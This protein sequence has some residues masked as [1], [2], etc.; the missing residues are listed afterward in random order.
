MRY[1]AVEKILGGRAVADIRKPIESA[2]G[3]PAAAYTSAEF[4]E[5]EQRRL[6]PQ[7]W[8][9]VA[10]AEEVAEPGDAMPVT[11]A[12]VPLIIL[13][14][15]AGE[16]RA[17][18]NVCRHRATIILEKPATKLGTLQC[19]YH[20]WTYGLDGSL[21][22]TPF[23]D[24]TRNASQRP[25]DKEKNGL[26]PARCGVWNHVVF[27]NLDGKAEPLADYV[28]PVDRFLAALDLGTLRLGH[29]HGWDFQAN[30]KLVNDNWENY[31]H[32]WVHEG[33]FDRM[34]DEVDLNTGESYTEMHPEGSVLVLRR[35]DG[36]PLRPG[37][38]PLATH[39]MPKIPVRAG[40]KPFIGCT[41]AVLP[42]TTV[43]IGVSSYVPTIYTPVAPG[44]THAHMAWYF[45]GDAATDTTHTEGRERVLDR[46]LG[47]S[48]KFEDR[49]GIR[50]QDHFCM[51]LQQAARFSPVA[52]MVQFS[53]T[54][55]RN[56]HYFEKWVVDKLADS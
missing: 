4:F 41:G 32:V 36:A 3:L 44:R 39:A 56:V 10:F 8:V 45:V 25:I 37:T 18:H 51:E 31:H 53:P 14:D 22:A 15:V 9:G 23:W 24:G 48:R 11:V 30:W 34:S 20:A 43:T 29:R 26:V 16:I 47:K 42:N 49:A 55:E 17:F 27:V 28:R 1:A 46:W 33:V 50:S 40:A 38:A 52:D 2:C 21:K 5:L 54:W 35:K 19:P 12:G 6:F 7:T 13:R